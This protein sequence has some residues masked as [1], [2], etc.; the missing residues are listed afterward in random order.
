MAEDNTAGEQ[1][2]DDEEEDEDEDEDEEESGRCSE[3]DEEGEAPK[4]ALAIFE[5]F[6]ARFR[7]GAGSP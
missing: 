3:K 1:D 7:R 4:V 6:E 2:D 5:L